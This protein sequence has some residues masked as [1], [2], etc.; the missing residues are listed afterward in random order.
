[1]K[2]VDESHNQVELK[3]SDSTENGLKT[4]NQVEKSSVKE[5][6]MIEKFVNDSKES[7]LND[8]KFDKFSKMVMFG[9]PKQA[10]LNKMAIENFTVEEIEKF[11]S[12]H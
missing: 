12:V 1:M 2:S 10:V 5:S 8:E 4:R 7:E 3:L 6:E 11:S 9:I